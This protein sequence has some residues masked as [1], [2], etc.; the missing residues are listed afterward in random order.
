MFCVCN[1]LHRFRLSNTLSLT[2]LGGCGTLEMQALDGHRKAL[3]WVSKAKPALLPVLPSDS[4]SASTYGLS[5]SCWHSVSLSNPLPPH[6]DAIIMWVCM[7]A[8]MSV[9]SC[10]H[11]FVFCFLLGPSTTETCSYIHNNS[12]SNPSYSPGWLWTHYVAKD[13]LK[14]LIVP[15]LCP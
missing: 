15:C 7:C 5:H 4:C 3:W 12:F 8:C 10:V 9:C 1:G 14:C 13:D 2:V 11:T 6:Q